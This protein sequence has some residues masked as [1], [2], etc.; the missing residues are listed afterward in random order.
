M[1]Y[2]IWGVECILAVSGITGGPITLPGPGQSLPLLPDP[3][4]PSVPSVRD[5]TGL[6]ARR[7]HF[8]TPSLSPLF[9]RRSG[10]RAAGG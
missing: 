8:V 10:S 6:H 9:A 2:N 1:M 7:I 5:A 4:P 3:F